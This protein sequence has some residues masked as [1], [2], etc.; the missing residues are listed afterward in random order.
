M[1]PGF[2]IATVTYNSLS[3]LREF[4]PGLARVAGELGTRIVAVDNAS[5][6]GSADFLESRRERTELIVERNRRNRGY[7][8]AVNQAFAAAPGSDLLLLNPDVAVDDP[9]QV[10]EMRAFMSGQPRAAVVAPKLLEPDSSVQSSA[11]V[12]PTLP[13]MAAHSSWIRHLGV[14]RR[15]AARYLQ[16][17]P[18]AEPSRVDWALGAAML[19]RRESFDSVG[20]WDESFFL[21]L[22][23]T[24][25]CLRCQRAGWETW[26]LPSVSLRH[27]HPRASDPAKGGLHRSAARRHHVRS[28]IRFFRR[29]PELAFRS[30]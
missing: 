6:D 7:A 1:A 20:G 2:A 3:E 10:E 11:R 4:F 26:Y 30:L 14:G 15:A 12:F 19:I 23:D 17:P 9:G 24:D 29:Y 13:A 28:T 16:I 25:F 21:Y 8:A 27:V 18:A 5:S 22:E